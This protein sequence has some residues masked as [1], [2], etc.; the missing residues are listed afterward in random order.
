MGGSSAPKGVIYRDAKSGLRTEV[1][2]LFLTYFML[3]WSEVSQS[4]SATKCVSCGGAM[5]GVEPVRD[6]KGKVF[7]GI[8]C[9]N[10]KTVLWTRKS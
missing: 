5:M 3:D 10:C 8:V 4:P 6:K 7:E 1:S 2:P 9:H